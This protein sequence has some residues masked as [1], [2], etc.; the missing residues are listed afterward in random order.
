MLKAGQEPYGPCASPAGPTSL[1]KLSSQQLNENNNGN[2]SK[3][4]E[5]RQEFSATFNNQLSSVKK[6]DESSSDRKSADALIP[7]FYPQP[8]QPE[9]SPFKI[10]QNQEEAKV[11]QTATATV[12]RAKKTFKRVM[13]G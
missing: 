10:E 7:N 9:T 12:N 3:L 5:R 2:L 8:Q 6:D 1:I 13:A 4:S 11:L